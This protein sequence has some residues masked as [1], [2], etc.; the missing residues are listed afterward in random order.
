MKHKFILNKIKQPYV[1]NIE[2]T[3]KDKIEN[4]T[5]FFSNSFLNE[6][7]NSVGDLEKK[8]LIISS[9][10]D[11]SYKE[12]LLHFYTNKIRIGLTTITSETE[13][14]N[15]NYLI[16]KYY[17][18]NG[19]FFS[20]T[21]I[22]LSEDFSTNS[23]N[24]QPYVVDGLVALVLKSIEP[25]SKLKLSFY[26]KDMEQCNYSLVIENTIDKLTNRET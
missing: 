12:L 9:L 6:K 15:R 25:N 20:K 10:K 22:L 5:L 11:V 23:E 17:G 1:V 2:N 13:E 24:L 21:L 18:T 8:G 14:N 7:F 4:I 16:Y 26:S 19:H 3:T